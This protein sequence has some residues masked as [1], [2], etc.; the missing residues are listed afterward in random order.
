MSFLG[1]VGWNEK[2]PWRICVEAIERKKVEVWRIG[3]WWVNPKEVGP[4]LKE[5][6]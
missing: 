2:T 1:H 6:G 5:E 3:W 4:T